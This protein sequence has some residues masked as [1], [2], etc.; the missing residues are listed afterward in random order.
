M[1]LSFILIPFVT[2]L[3]LLFIKNDKSANTIAIVSTLGT[4]V[5]A[6]VVAGN[7][8]VDFNA[9]WIPVLNAQFLLHA[10]GL[11]KILVLLTAISFP[12]IIIATSQNQPKQK[13]IFLSLLLF[14][15]S[16]LMGVFLAGDA[17]LFYFFWELA[18]IP[19]YFLSSIWGGEKRIAV[20]F[21]FFIYTF[22]GS[23]MMLIGIVYVYMH[24]SDQSFL[25]Q[26]FAKANLTGGQ[27]VTAFALFFIAFAIKMP[28]F[29][30]HTWQPDAYEQA[31]TAVTMVMS[32]VMVKMG[33]YGILRWLLPLFPTA[34]V[35]HI[36]VVVILS[37]IGILYAS[38]IAIRQ[39]DIKRLIAYSSIAH[40]GLMNA[41]IFSH[42]QIGIQGAMFQLFSH[43]INVLGLWI[44]ADIIEQQT[45]TR[46]MQQMGGLA[47]KQ[48]TL[49]IL[50]VGFAL[51][52][53]ALPL[54]NAFVGE[55][56]MFNSLFQYNVWVGAAA[57][58]SIILAAIYTLNMVQKVAYG[59]VST[60]INQ[61]Q[62]INKPAQIVLIVL[63]II[64]FVTGVFPQ[65]LFDLTA[66]SLQ[67]IIVK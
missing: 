60:Q 62:T 52:N 23:L 44:I 13:N 12:A 9:P 16:G 46:S 42:H 26:S 39:D 20:T 38:F 30:L 58:V 21:K 31:P 1:L 15:Q 24:T 11:A 5:A 25:I 59:E 47:K 66:D 53:I 64:V 33:L 50:L 45:G 43:G 35:A 27:Q 10:D 19:V 6:I 18:L 4:L 34:F 37:V 54:T 2:A 55:F 65:P 22:L 17:L 51:A 8:A 56:L 36:N 67:Q 40:I 14:T 48:P 32:A 7:G 3:L 57:G 29:P 41:A 49:A 28:I 61:M 63:L